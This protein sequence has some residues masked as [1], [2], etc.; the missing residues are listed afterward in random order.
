M[1]LF[2]LPVYHVGYFR[3][4]IQILQT[5]CKS[6]GSVLLKQTDS[7]HLQGEAEE[8]K[9]GILEEEDSGEGKEVQCQVSSKEWGGEKVWTFENIS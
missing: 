7:G 2:Q 9:H 5:I 8:S 3:S 6:K 1:I 4:I